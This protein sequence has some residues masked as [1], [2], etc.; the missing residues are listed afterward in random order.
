[1]LLYT[2]TRMPTPPALPHDHANFMYMVPEA[3]EIRPGLPGRHVTR[4]TKDA[5]R[6]EQTL[7]DSLWPEGRSHL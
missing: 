6:F 7:Q 1:M 2:L 4:A 3:R 5:A